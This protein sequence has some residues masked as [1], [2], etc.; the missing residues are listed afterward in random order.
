V[1]DAAWHD[2]LYT[3]HRERIMH[4]LIRMLNGDKAAAEDLTQ[5]TFVTAW[6]KRNS[7]PED[8]SAGWWWWQRII[9]AISGER[10]D[11]IAPSH[12]TV[13]SWIAST[14]HLVRIASSSPAAFA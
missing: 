7:V 14:P 1:R 13:R 9:C 5:E 10:N 8:P 11:V 12:S 3:E 6:K 4:V 2:A